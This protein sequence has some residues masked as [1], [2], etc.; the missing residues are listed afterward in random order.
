M[1]RAVPPAQAF[2]GNTESPGPGD[3]VHCHILVLHFHLDSFHLIEAEIFS[4][5]YPHTYQISEFQ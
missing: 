1:A 2:P 4:P 3:N 5:E